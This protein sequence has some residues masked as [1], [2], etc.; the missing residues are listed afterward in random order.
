MPQITLRLAGYQPAR[1]V[2]TRAMYVFI[3]AMRR[4]LGDR[5][6]VQYVENVTV[7]GRNAADLFTM[8]EG[9]ELDL[10][11]FSSSYLAGRVPS[12]GLFDLPFPA[13]DRHKVYALTDGPAGRRLAEDVAAATGFSVLAYWDNGFRHITNNRHPIVHPRDCRGLKIRTLDNALYQ[14]VLRS[15]GFEPI[16]I[17]VKELA[18]AVNEGRVDAQENPLTNVIN[19][20]LHKAQRFLTLTSHFFGVAL[21][22]CNRARLRQ[23]PDEVGEA[24]AAAMTE[25]T[26]VQRRLAAEDD[27]L[28]LAAL[29][30]DGVNVT[31]ADAFDRAAFIDAVA[32]IR[33]EAMRAAGVTERS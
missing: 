28:C 33:A 23:W 29:E 20:N 15:I 31:D 10:F 26:A 6:D 13:T 22:L 16:V 27:E 11:Y 2:L 32:D 3:D 1:S 30:E 19:F 24:V 14:G 18:A 7:T 5:V 4:R 17:D 21:V 12:L 9:D 25:A 8:T